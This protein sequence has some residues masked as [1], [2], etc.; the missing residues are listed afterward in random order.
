MKKVL[1][2]AT[3]VRLHINVFHLPYIQW[4]HEQGW[5]VDVAARNDFDNPDDCEIP[6]CDHYY[7]I[8]FERSPLKF[9]NLKAYKELKKLIDKEQYDLIHCHTPVGGVAARVAARKCRK[10][11]KTKVAYTAHGFHFYSG[12]PILNWLLFYP[13]EKLLAHQTDLLIT[14]NSEDYARAKKFKARKVAYVNGVGLDLARF[15]PENEAKRLEV[16]K[17]LCLGQNDIFAITVGNLIKRKNQIT[18]IEAVKKVNNPYLQLFICG[19]GPYLDVLKKK[20]RELKIE[21]QIHFLGFR[22]DVENLCGAADLFLFASLQEGLP[23]AVM[24]AMACGLPIITSKIRGNI[25]LIDSGKGGYLVQPTDVDGFAKAIVSVIK[26]ENKVKQME[27]HNLKK[28][29]DYSRDKVIDQMA[30]LYKSLM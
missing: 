4:F 26:N 25:D 13:I 16:R 9:S 3:V 24:E 18:L 6:F 2:V 7:N 27:I 8:P 12:A 14:M 1:F 11:G 22:K 23:V 29:K 30:K 19:D 28:I 21:K 15:L 20:T 17:K 10:S 5:Q